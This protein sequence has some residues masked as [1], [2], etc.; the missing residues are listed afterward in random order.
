MEVAPPPPTPPPTTIS[1]VHNNQNKTEHKRPIF[2]TTPTSGSFE[3]P[4]RSVS[5]HYQ[6]IFIDTGMSLLSLS[7]H[8]R[9]QQEASVTKATVPTGSSSSCYKIS[10]RQRWIP[11]KWHPKQWYC[12]HVLCV[13]SPQGQSELWLPIQR[14]LSVSEG[15]LHLHTVRVPLRCIM[16]KSLF[17]GSLHHPSFFLFFVVFCSYVSVAP[18]LK[19]GSPQRWPLSHF[20]NSCQ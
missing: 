14:L 4:L 16:A 1:C 6:S 13:F 18:L 17:T 7:L 20:G 10:G 2:F 19:T 5:V 11:S 8:P 3:T 12:P 9:T 15:S